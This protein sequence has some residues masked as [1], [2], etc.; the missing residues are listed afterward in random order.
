MPADAW[1]LI[2]LVAFVIA[3]LVAFGVDLASRPVASDE[4]G[5]ESDMAEGPMGASKRTE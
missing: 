4:E 2:V 5:R 3:L 1:V